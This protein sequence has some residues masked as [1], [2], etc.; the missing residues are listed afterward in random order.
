MQ[1][2]GISTFMQEMKDV[3][4]VLNNATSNSLVIIDE[5]GRG[6]STFD[7]FGLIYAISDEIVCNIKAFTLLATHFHE[8]V[9]RC[10]LMISI[11]LGS[12]RACLSDDGQELESFHSSGR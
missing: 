3:S 5:L 11:Y 6:T 7:G 12:T 9:L 8:M 10:D 2:K 1:S 4:V